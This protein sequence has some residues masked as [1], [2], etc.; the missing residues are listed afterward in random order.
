MGG[1]SLALAADAS[2]P[3]A[4]APPPRR[5]RLGARLPRPPTALLPLPLRPS[6]RRGQAGVSRRLPLQLL[7]PLREAAAAVEAA[8]AL[9]TYRRRPSLPKVPPP[10]LRSLPR[11][12]G[13]RRACLP[14]LSAAPLRTEARKCSLFFVPPFGR[15]TENTQFC[16]HSKN[17]P[18]LTK[19]ALVTPRTEVA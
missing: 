19:Q 17:T 15:E 12:A 14:L 8:A 16:S 1:A 3:A 4:G 7:L 9:L 5:P 13:S 11:R 18:S 2:S 6:R 10:P